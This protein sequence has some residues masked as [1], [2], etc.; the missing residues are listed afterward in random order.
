MR[1]EAAGRALEPLSM[2]MPDCAAAV[3]ALRGRGRIDVEDWQPCPPRPGLD[4]LLNLE[5]GAGGAV[6]RRKATGEE[7]FEL[8]PAGEP[9]GDADDLARD[10]EADRLLE[11]AETISEFCE[12]PAPARADGKLDMV[13]EEGPGLTE[14]KD[15][16]GHG[17]GEDREVAGRVQVHTDP[18]IGGEGG[19]NRFTPSRRGYGRPTN[20]ASIWCVA[21][22]IDIAA[23]GIY[24]FI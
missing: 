17:L 3:A 4:H 19:W 24:F 8:D 16:S 13:G 20:R 9:A 1:D 2:P 14:T 22:Y 10:L 15:E 7:P 23:V 6:L 18:A 11:G 12:P 21:A 5:E